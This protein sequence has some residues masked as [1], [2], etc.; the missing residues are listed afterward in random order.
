MAPKEDAYTGSQIEVLEGLKPVRLRPGMY[1]GSTGSQGLHHL[2]YEMI[3]NAIDENL[4][5]F[6]DKINVTINKNMEVSVEDNG[7]G[8][9]VDLMA[10]TKDFPKSKYKKGICSERVVLT[11]LHAGGKFKSGSY[12]VSGGL[13]GV[14]IAVVNA[15]SSYVKVEVFRDG[16]HYVDEYKDGGTPITPLHQ[17]EL[18]PI[19]KTNKRGTKVTFKPDP[20]IFET[21][22]FKGQILKKRLHELAF[23]NPGL[24]IYFK[25]ETLDKVEEIEYFEEEGII[26][27]IKHLT[28]DKTAIIEPIFVSGSK[29]NIEIA[30]AFQIGLE[31]NET[32]YSFCNNI[33]TTEGGTHVTGF[34]SALTKLINRYAK[35]LN[36]LKG[37]DNLDGKDVRNGITAI[38]SIKHPNPQ[39]EGQT[40]TKIGNS[41][42]RT[43]TEEIF[44]QKGELFFDRNVAIVTK[45]VENAIKS[46]DIRKKE[47]KSREN[48][49]ATTTATPPSKLAHCQFQNNEK[50]KICTEIYLVEGDSAGGSAKSARNRKFQ[51]ILPLKGKVLNIEKASVRKMLENEE[52]LA[53]INAFGCGF[54]EGYGNDFDISKLKYGKIVIMTDADV[55]GAHIR[56][57]I[58]TLIYRLMPEL[59]INGHVFIAQPPLYKVFKKNQP[60]NFD[61]AYSDKELQAV[62]KKK[63]IKEPIIQRFKGL[64][65][66]NPEQ[67][68][69]TTM[70]PE[71]RTFLEVTIDDAI[72]AD[73][74]TSILMGSSVQPRR[75]F[76]EEEAEHAT[77]NV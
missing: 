33:N 10:N 24:R 73:Q 14:G 34:K 65:E 46:Y 47:S 55:D 62:I 13:H 6:C 54:G 72:Y 5:G 27:F 50:K 58:L 77:I 71:T 42:A 44:N 45:I 75:E 15:L 32:I 38:V 39:F 57:L 63:Q 76:I 30:I 43:V 9:P 18:K 16:N 37:R 11:T 56:T 12:K 52:I 17:G 48:Y 41:D 67:L 36:L 40:K 22:K 4:A 64:G 70:N 3:D 53:I 61:Y 23:L 20:E 49:L 25:D 66:M 51:A 31:F 2:V 19:G 69:D 7:R 35:D 21:V 28:K 68:W 1:I 59:I 74:I 8:I 26:G 29:D 60:K